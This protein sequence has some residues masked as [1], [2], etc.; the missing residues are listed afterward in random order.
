MLENDD[1][2]LLVT[3]ISLQGNGG[4]FLIENIRSNPNYS[5]LPII[6]M[7]DI[8]SNED[9]GNI[10]ELGANLFLPKP[11]DMFDFV[12]SIEGHVNKSIQA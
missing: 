5:R 12:V 10:Y 1:F 8:I 2:D 6:V 11:I 9:I 7:S 3:N 4:R